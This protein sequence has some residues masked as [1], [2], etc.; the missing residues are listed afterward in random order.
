VFEPLFGFRLLARFAASFG[1]VG[2]N[3]PAEDA[4]VRPVFSLGRIRIIGGLREFRKIAKN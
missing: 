2:R 3:T 1:K 4:G